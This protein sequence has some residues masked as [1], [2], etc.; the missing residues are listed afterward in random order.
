[1]RDNILITYI[2]ADILFV[3]S[4]GLLIIFALTTEAE[5]SQTP[6]IKTV[7]RN[8]LLNMCPLS[9]QYR[10]AFGMCGRC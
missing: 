10:G 7:A 2:V 1:M 4:G 3:V 9:G 5:T 8:L 6:T